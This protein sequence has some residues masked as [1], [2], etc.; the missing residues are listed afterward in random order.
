MSAMDE[1]KKVLEEI[2][3]KKKELATYDQQVQ[4]LYNK[5][6]PLHQDLDFLYEKK[7]LAEQAFLVELENEV[8]KS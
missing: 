2:A 1:F 7:R 6:S 3:D 4:E 5:M 8:S